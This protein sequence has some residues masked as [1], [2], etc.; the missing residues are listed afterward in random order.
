[1]D[2]YIDTFGFFHE[3]FVRYRIAAENKA[4][5]ITFQSKAD[6]AVTNVDCRKGC[7]FDTVLI[8]NYSS[9]GEVKFMGNDFATGVRQCANS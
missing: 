4:Q 7:H 5:T 8:V 9:L 2:C 6:R 1:M 3:P